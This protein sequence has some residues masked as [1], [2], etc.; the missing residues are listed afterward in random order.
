MGTKLDAQSLM[1]TNK[2][3][4]SRI[5]SHQDAG[6]VDAHDELD[7]LEKVSYKFH[8]IVCLDLLLFSTW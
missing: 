1:L 5:L 4:K 8:P 2:T 6:C 7:I 3:S